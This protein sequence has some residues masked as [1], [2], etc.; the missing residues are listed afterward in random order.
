MSE[1]RS[2][3]EDFWPLMT[4][5]VV[6]YLLFRAFQ[7]DLAFRLNWAGIVFGG[8]LFGTAM[9]AGALVRGKPVGTAVAFGIAFAGLQF[10]SAALGDN[11]IDSGLTFA[12]GIL[13]ICVFRPWRE[14]RE[15]TETTS[16]QPH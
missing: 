15:Q 1:R 8:L 11:W 6:A 4:G 16:E 2:G 13:V 12:V 10:G 14:H 5:M 7:L 3:N 9:S